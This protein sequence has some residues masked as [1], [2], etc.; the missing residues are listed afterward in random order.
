MT[1]GDK[2]SEEDEVL[3]LRPLFEDTLVDPTAHELEFDFGHGLQFRL[4]QRPE[5][6]ASQRAG[7]IWLCL[8]ACLRTDYA[9][10][11]ACMNAA[12][13]VL[14]CVS[15]VRT[16]GE[17]AANRLHGLG[18][19]RRP[20]RDALCCREEIRGTSRTS[21]LGAG[22]G[23][24]PGMVA[25][26]AFGCQ[27]ILTDLEDVVP[28]LAQNVALNSSTALV[29]A[30]QWGKDPAVEWGAALHPPFGLLLA[31]DCLYDTGNVPP[32][33]DSL[34]AL[35]GPESQALVSFDTALGRWGAYSAFEALVRERWASVE[36]LPLAWQHPRFRK[37]EVK[38]FRLGE[39][40]ADMGLSA[41]CGIGRGAVLRKA[42]ALGR[43][44][45]P[46]LFSRS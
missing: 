19:G 33:V 18:W 28:Q 16:H 35:S 5:S 38:I 14:T 1:S 43:D 41:P 12:K 27:A 39:Y 24:L 22:E 21:R 9:A 30:L 7:T 26:R 10:V 13:H 25:S 4:L 3:T 36:E 45:L 20:R 6:F 8:L 15:F 34:C 11:H 29:Q 17:R 2:E 46:G 42:A 32:F 23:G 37:H 31:A 44:H 40:A